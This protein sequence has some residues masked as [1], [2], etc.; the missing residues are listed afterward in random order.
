[1]TNGISYL[2]AYFRG[3]F[4]CIRI[5]EAHIKVARKGPSVASPVL[6][7]ARQVSEHRPRLS[8]TIGESEET[9]THGKIALLSYAIFEKGIVSIVR[10][11]RIPHSNELNNTA[12][13]HQTYDLIDPSV[14]IGPF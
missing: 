12:P 13:G 8:P 2:V 1:M 5:D 3:V 10:P 9:G 14:S 11:V 7:G 4:I 6:L